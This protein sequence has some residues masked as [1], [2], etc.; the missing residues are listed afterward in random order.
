MIRSN[1][2]H[3]AVAFLG[4]GAWAVFAN[5]AHG[6]EAWLAG[7]VQGALSATI[8]LFLKRMTEA[9]SARA[10][11]LWRLALPP[12]LAVGASLAILTTVHH[13]AGTPEIATTIALP[14]SVTALYASLYAVA[15]WRDRWRPR[16]AA[17]W[18]AVR[19]AGPPR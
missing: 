5:R 15:L 4:M 18:P 16:T 19:R 10:S 9:V 6:G 2:L 7:L 13:L 12:V 14:L 11:G 1:A 3:L 17:R 8:N